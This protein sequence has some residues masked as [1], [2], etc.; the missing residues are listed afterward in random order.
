MSEA[1]LVPFPVLP[2]ELIFMIF[3]HL[4]LQNPS[5]ALDLVLVSKSVQQL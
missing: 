3:E 4:V 2:V 5:S 1:E